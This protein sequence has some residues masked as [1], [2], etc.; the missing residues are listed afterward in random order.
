MAGLGAGNEQV[1]GLNEQGTAAVAKL[2]LADGG[3]TDFAIAAEV[4]E[5]LGFDVPLV[6]PGFQLRR[7]LGGV[8][9]GVFHIQL[10][11]SEP[12]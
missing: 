3:E 6:R 7:Q 4:G 10:E 1:T 8:T 2:S 12:T 5:D 11:A 9:Y